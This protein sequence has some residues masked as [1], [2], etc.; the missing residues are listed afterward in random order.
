MLLEDEKDLGVCLVDIGGGTTDIAVFDDGA[1]QHTAVIP[2]A[3]DHVTN[4]IAV[5]LRTPTQCAEAIK[6]RHAC[7]LAEAGGAGR[8]HRGAERR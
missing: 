1:I 3:G 8:D 6:V 7:A 2:I 4:D 5:A